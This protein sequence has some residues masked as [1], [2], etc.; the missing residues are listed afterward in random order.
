[1]FLFKKI[2]SPL[3]LPLPFCMGLLLVGLL[4]LWFTRRQR[5]GKIISTFAVAL[6]LLLSY[7]PV[8]NFLLGRLESRHVP[9]LLSTGPEAGAPAELS[10][11]KWIVVLG[12]GHKSDSKVTAV[13]N[14][15]PSTLYRLVEA[16]GLHRRIPG[17]K[18]IVSGSDVFRLDSEAQA[19]AK[20]AEALGVDRQNIVLE[21][22]SN[23]TEEQ[24]VFIKRIVGGDPF[25]MVTSASHMARAVALFQK[26]GMNPVPAPTRHRIVEGTLMPRDY[27]PSP[28]NLENSEVAVYE[29]MGMMWARLRGK[30]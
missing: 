12:G 10:A 16:I 9:V 29:Y 3:L 4:L 15:S 28:E 18:L 17:S 6:L 13:A 30:V 1:M 20:V 22:Q 7:G 24:A 26:Q 25:I 2:I 5:A 27:F 8:P 23:D 11:A 14:L 21:E 19:M